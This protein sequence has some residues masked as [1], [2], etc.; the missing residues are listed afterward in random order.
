MDTIKRSDIESGEVCFLLDIYYF[1]AIYRFSTVPIEI[2]D[3]SEGTSIPYRGA[4]SDPPVNL[5]SDL[6]GVD[7]EA[8]TISLELVFEEID[9]V[10]EFLKGRTLNDALCDLSMVIIKD[11]KTSFTQQDR[12]GIF[13][14][15]A[16]DSIFGN[17]DA[18]KGAVAFSI[19]NS[20]NIRDRK[21]LGEEHII[22]DD[23]YPIGIIEKSRGKV[24]PFVFGS[25]FTAPIET[26]GSITFEEDLR[27]TPCYQAGGTPTLKTQYFQVAY[28]T[29]T[30][31][32]TS[33]IKIYDGQGGS[34]T[35]PVEIAIDSKGFLHAYVPYYLNVGSPEGTNFQEDNFQVSSPEIAFQYYAEWSR[36]DGGIPSIN[37]DGPLESAV[38]ISL[39]A[40][41][42]SEL[43]FDYS[44]WQGLAP[45]LNRYKFGGYVNDLDLTA[46][47]WVK[48][49]IW[50]LLP[51]MV[52]TGGR[53]IKASL[54]LYTYAQ[55]I[56]PSHYL[57]DSGEI[58]IISPLTPLEGDIINRIVL[59]FA[60][61]GNAGAYR[62]QV[63][64]DPRLTEDEPLKFRDPLAYISYTRYGLREKV[65]EAPF[66]YDLQTAIRIA[67]DKIRAHALGN[68]AIEISA[69]P[70][71][72]YLDLGDIV[73]ITSERVG[74]TEHKCQI[75]S[76]S[77]N[78]NR[79]R[80]VLHIEDNPLVT[81]RS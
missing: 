10:S 2:E 5:Q 37:G 81:I 36:S 64:I 22:F 18:P 9:W 77:W 69:S 34:F 41:E 14:G 32:G 74:L 66:V 71:Y 65:I 56:I 52:T 48:Q 60:Y 54:N 46:Y 50:D 30:I 67:R 80:Y 61:A 79:W 70:R 13:S 72:G 42:R 55:E 19:E 4:L 43:L 57:I 8:N 33:Y 6:L 1:G 12:I 38:D 40:L 35:N 17:P 45:V 15:R 75:V 31:Q 28:H 26:S 78:N 25:P 16:L 49:N 20:I 29:V 62:S 73:A 23:N 51:I 47:E 44:S 24:V 27:V 63:I 58:E 39:Y 53:G 11:G 76:K 7:L 21:L 68:Y 3:I 59:R